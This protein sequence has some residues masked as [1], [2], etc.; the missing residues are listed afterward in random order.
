MI[1]TYS[2]KY[3]PPMP[4]LSV[5]LSFP[6]SDQWHGPHIG[7][8]DSGADY[9][10]IPLSNLAPIDPPS[11]G[12]AN[13]VSQWEDRREVTV[14]HLD[15]RIGNVVLQS[16]EVAGD[17]DSKEVILGRNVLNDLMLCLNGPEVQLELVE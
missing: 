9:T 6:D 15:I 17:P 2:F 12:S 16:V 8:V 10:I 11:V 4:V 7:I 1:Q 13:L 5:L 3:Y 14:Y